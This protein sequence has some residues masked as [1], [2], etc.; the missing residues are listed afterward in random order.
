[1]PEDIYEKLARHLDDLPAGFPRTQAAAEMRILRRLFTPE[2]TNI[3]LHLTL[4]PEEP[5]VIARRVGI[6]VE[7]ASARLS[8]MEKRGL[9]YGHHREGQPAR[10][11]AQ[12]FVIGFWE[13]QVNRLNRD[14]IKDFEAY[15]PDFV[16]YELWRKA[17]QLRTIPVEKSLN[18]ENKVMPYEQAAELIRTQKIF[19]V[20]NCICRQEMRVLGNGCEKP[21]ESCL[22]FGTAARSV[23]YNNRGRYID[24]EE[25]LSILERA[26]T[27]GLILQPANAKEALWICTCCGC[28]CG[29]LRSLKCHPKPGTLISSAF[30][31]SL[32]PTVCEACGV[33]IDRCQMDAIS[34]K[35]DVVVLDSDRCI[36]CGLCV[37]SCPTG[38]LS[39]VRKPE[40]DLPDVPDTIV[41]SY[42]RLGRIRGK[43]GTGKL[44][45][46]QVKSKLDRLLVLFETST[47]W[48]GD[49]I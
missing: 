31:T 27:A 8:D 11:R 17:P 35:G 2:D 14:L 12:Q 5:R 16:D 46:M 9:V 24:K 37:S 28:C 22:S 13:G 43:L 18:T 23:V 30:L 49:R 10:Y 25:T 40:S 47:K 29:V 4:I 20:S 45:R 42:I 26:E 44:F 32:D 39:L 3:A 21:E 48:K 41:E 15:L 36:G 6:S 33:C 1:M 38:A 34:L 7:E 19:A